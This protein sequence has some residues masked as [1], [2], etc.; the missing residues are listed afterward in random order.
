VSAAVS[1]MSVA[2]SILELAGIRVRAAEFSAPSL[3]PLTRDQPGSV[4]LQPVVSGVVWT[5]GS[6]VDERHAVGFD[7]YRYISAAIPGKDEL[8]DGRADPG[9]QRSIAESAPEPLAKARQLLTEHAR[10]SRELRSR[11]Q[12]EN[13]EL[14]LDDAT[15]KRL[16]TLGYV[17]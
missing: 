6:F 4:T 8:F 10:Q 2:P 12:I 17:Q 1:T 13:A 11:L 16:R 9:E 5:E 7:E 15:L 3:A 14:G